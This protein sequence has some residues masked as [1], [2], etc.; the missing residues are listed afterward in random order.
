MRK[1]LTENAYY[2]LARLTRISKT[3]GE[4]RFVGEWTRG[5]K[6]WVVRCSSQ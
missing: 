5:S 4:N 3:T 1:T 6:N 2:L